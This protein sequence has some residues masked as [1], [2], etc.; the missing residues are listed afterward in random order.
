MSKRLGVV[1]NPTAGKGRAAR[2]GPAVIG[3]LLEAGHDVWDL[4]GATADLG[5]EHARRAVADGIDALVVVGGDG[6]VHLGAQAVASTSTSLAILAMG[7]GNDFARNLGLPVGD[8]AACIDTLLAT[9]AADARPPRAIDALRVTGPGLTSRKVAGEPLRWVAGAVSAGLDAAVNER[10]NAMVRPRGSSRY[11][12]AAL[13][14]IAAWSAWDY[15]LTFEQVPG[16]PAE[17]AAITSLDG[18]GDLGDDADGTRLVWDARGALVTVANGSHIGGG[19]PVAPLASIDD[20]YADV[21]IAT[22][23]GR[24]G[25]ITLF[26]QLLRGRNLRNPQVR[27][28]R[29]RAVTLEPAEHGRLPRIPSVFGDG[30]FLGTLPLRVEVCPRALRVLAP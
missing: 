14:E 21:I 4:T 25:A 24:R 13:R 29:A 18:F 10:A 9:L 30:E 27:M 15:R 26:P 28:V 12:I 23:V 22:D 3:A 17:I 19:I 6:M 2:A 7:T 8:V 20:G 11:V 1:I 5:L 16:T